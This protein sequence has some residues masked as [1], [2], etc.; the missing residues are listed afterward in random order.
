MALN[1]SLDLLQYPVGSLV[2][3]SVYDPSS[4]ALVHVLPSPSG[5]GHERGTDQ[6]GEDTGRRKERTGNLLSNRNDAELI[7]GS[8][9]TTSNR[10]V[11]G[12]RPIPL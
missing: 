3:E 12:S 8:A 1:E 7:S 4:V 6:I 11:Q 2:S 10:S 9:I 5:S